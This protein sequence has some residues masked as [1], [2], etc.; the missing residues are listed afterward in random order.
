MAVSLFFA[1]L[2][3]VY[4]LIAGLVLALRKEFFQRALTSFLESSALLFFSG[5]M[6]L[7]FGLLILFAHPVFG[8]NWRLWITLLGILAVFKGI[9]RLFMTEKEKTWLITFWQGK[10]IGYA[11]YLMILLG[12]YLAYHGFF[13]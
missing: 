5:M 13:K 7:L 2:L 8:F 12:L 1:K 6:S 11:G 3:G 9:L 10:K 4:L